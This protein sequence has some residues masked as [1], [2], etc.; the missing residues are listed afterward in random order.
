MAGEG[1]TG[2][3]SEKKETCRQWDKKKKRRSSNDVR[4]SESETKNAAKGKKSA[5]NSKLKGV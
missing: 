4:E 3:E 2:G 1:R 5:K